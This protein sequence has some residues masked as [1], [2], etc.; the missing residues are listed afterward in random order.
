[1]AINFSLP[2]TGDRM[3][4]GKINSVFNVKENKCNGKRN[5]GNRLRAKSC[6]TSKKKMNVGT[7]QLI[8]AHYIKNKKLSKHAIQQIP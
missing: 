4:I 3:Y 6:P 1:M 5:K 7:R 8:S 2:I